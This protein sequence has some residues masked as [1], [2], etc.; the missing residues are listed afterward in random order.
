[1]APDTSFAFTAQ[2]TSAQLTT[3]VRHATRPATR[4]FRILGPV[5]ALYGV[6]ELIST[7]PDRVLGLYCIAF[8]AIAAF[9]LPIFLVR[10]SVHRLRSRLGDT[11]SYRIDDQGVRSVTRNT[12]GLVRWPAIDRLDPLSEDLILMWLGKNQFIP[13]VIGDVPTETKAALLGFIQ[14]HLHRPASIHGQPA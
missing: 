1:M 8:G 11:I 2:L 6:L 4:L 3:A 7:P 12:D 10:R 5:A 14:S 9:G 13:V